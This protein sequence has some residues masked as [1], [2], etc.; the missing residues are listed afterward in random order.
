VQAL[1]S[2]AVYGTP[3]RSAT[4]F[5]NRRLNMLLAVLEKRCGFKLAS[6]DV[7]INIAGGLRIDDPALDLAVVSAVL[8]SNAN[9]PL[10]K[11][12][13][14]TGEVGLTGEVRAVS[15]LEQRV[16]EAEKLGFERIFISRH[17]KTNLKGAGIEVVAVSKVEEVYRLLFS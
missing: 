1:V 8:S 16:A 15:R 6:K 11:N 13:C 2:T 5:D 4:G 17:N 7:F 9:E 10:P 3:Q 12:C 14:F